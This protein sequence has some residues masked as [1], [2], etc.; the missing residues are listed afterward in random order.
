MLDVEDIFAELHATVC[1][2]LGDDF[3]VDL[4]V[5]DPEEFPARRNMA[6]TVRN[7]RGDLCIV[8]APKLVVSD[9][10]SRVQGVL[11]HEFGHAAL[12]HL[13]RNNHS[14]R[15]ADAMGEDLFGDPIYYDEETVQTLSSGIRPRPNHLPK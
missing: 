1:E 11:R 5:G 9:D 8:V 12:W 2:R 15:D 10:E 13:E 3:Y 14:E 6:Y 7:K 4:A